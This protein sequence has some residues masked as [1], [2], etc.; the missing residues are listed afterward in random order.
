MSGIDERRQKRLVF[1]GLFIIFNLLFLSVSFGADFPTKTVELVMPN[2]PGG[3]AD[4]TARILSKRLSVLLGQ[5]VVVVN[6]AGGGQAIGI[7]SVL[8]APADGHTILISE[9]SLVVLPLLTK[10]IPFT[11]KD[12]TPIN[13]A[14]SAPLCLIVKKDALWKSFEEVVAEAKKNPEKLNFSSGGPGSTARLAGELFQIS[15]NTKLTHVPMNGASVAL[16][17]VLGGQVDLSFLGFQLIKSHLEAGSLRA[18][19]ALYDKRL[20]D[21]PDLPTTVEKGYPKLTVPVW[22]GFFVPAK[23]PAAVVQKLGAVFNQVLKEREVADQI[24]KTGLLIENL[25]PEEAAKFI[26][27]EERKWSEVAKT[28]NILPK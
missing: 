17:A 20:K 23:T 11:I 24:E 16:T 19:A 18:L 21:Y 6:K 25:N 15:T 5:S 27:A 10:G 26:A 12:F 14:T 8:T 13:L 2:P 4:T 9:I 22:I 28:A 3:P 7:Q 1:I